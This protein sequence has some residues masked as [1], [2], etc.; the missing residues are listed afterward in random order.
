[1]S[2]NMIPPVGGGW[3]AAAKQIGPL[4]VFGYSPDETAFFRLMLDRESVAGSLV[5]I[6]PQLIAYSFNAASRPV[7]LDVQSIR[8]DEILLL[9]TFFMVVVHYGTTV[10]QWRR[11]GYQDQPEHQAFRWASASLCVCFNL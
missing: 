2:K 7:L 9:D 6:H 8:A 5:M 11:A 1:M 3:H 4:Q 10:A